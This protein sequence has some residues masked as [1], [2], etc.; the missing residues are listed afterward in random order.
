MYGL[1]P[2][3]FTVHPA[4]RREAVLSRDLGVFTWAQLQATYPNGS[5]ALAALPAGATAFV[6]DA[7]KTV[8]QVWPNASKTRWVPVNSSA[9]LFAFGGDL[10]SPVHTWA[11]ATGSAAFAGGNPTVAA[12]LLSGGDTFK[13]IALLR[14]RGAN[15]TAG[16]NLRFGTAGTTADQPILGDALANF[17]NRQYRIDQDLSVAD[18]SSYFTSNWQGPSSQQTG[19]GL[20]RVSNVNLAAAMYFSADVSSINASDFVDLVYWRVEWFAQ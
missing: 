1:E 11:G 8:I 15:A 19:A 17:D 6:T 4:S 18:A 10:A 5:G 7:C 3:P 12:G 14:K 13:S 16:F 9:V 2:I 20:D